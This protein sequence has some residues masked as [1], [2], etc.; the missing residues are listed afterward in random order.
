MIATLLYI[1]YRTYH[2]SGCVKFEL[3]YKK[4]II[5]NRDDQSVCTKMFTLWSVF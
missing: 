5:L 4:K 1:I 2:C 3:N